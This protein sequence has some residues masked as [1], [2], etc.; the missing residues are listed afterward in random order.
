MGTP[1]SRTST[2]EARTTFTS[3]HLLTVA[4]SFNLSRTWLAAASTSSAP[5]GTV[6]EP[7][8]SNLLGGL[9]ALGTYYRVYVLCT[10]DFAGRLYR[11]HQ[12]QSV[13]KRSTCSETSVLIYDKHL[14]GR[15]LA[16]LG[17][18]PIYCACKLCC[19]LG[20][21]TPHY[22]GESAYTWTCLPAG[23][24]TYSS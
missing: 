16:M 10:G 2:A 12:S 4:F 14:H 8:H 23:P 3:Q 11:T 7:R 17:A 13:N 22:Q 5:P 24:N 21:A 20:L 9:T 6:T 18:S 15:N 19:K 1:S